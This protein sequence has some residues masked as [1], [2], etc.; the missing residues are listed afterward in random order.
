MLAFAPLTRLRER[1]ADPFAG[2]KVR[3]ADVLYGADACA[4]HNHA[5]AHGKLVFIDGKEERE[6]EREV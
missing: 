2:A 5:L 4:L 6:R 1:D 3:G